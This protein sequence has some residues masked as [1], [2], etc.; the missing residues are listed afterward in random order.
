MSSY[1]FGSKDNFDRMARA[2]RYAEA[3]QRGDFPKTY[4]TQ[5]GP[6]VIVRITKTV[7][8]DFS[9]GYVFTTPDTEDVVLASTG[10][11]IGRFTY[12]NTKATTNED[13]WFDGGRCVVA[14]L[15]GEDLKYG[16]RYKGFVTDN[17]PDDSYPVVLVTVPVSLDSTPCVEAVCDCVDSPEGAAPE[18]EF[19]ADDLT[20]SGFS[21]SDTTPVSPFSMLGGDWSL[22]Y[23]NE[24]GNSA[25]RDSSDP[26]WSMAL[27]GEEWVLTGTGLNEEKIFFIATVFDYCNGGVF[28]FDS[29]EGVGSLIY[30]GPQTITLTGAGP[31]SCNQSSSSSSGVEI[32][33]DVSCDGGGLKVDKET[34]TGFVMIGGKRFPVVFELS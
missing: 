8:A 14:G 32:V 34:L 28:T 10:A 11:F 23:I 20:L 29:M 4:P 7:K 15:N 6:E 26:L 33:S 30:T 18:F 21:Q 19:F 17:T 22:K 3:M 9:Q 2:V 31:C 1:V 27:E 5:S 24:E 12:R 13:A 16:C 25:W